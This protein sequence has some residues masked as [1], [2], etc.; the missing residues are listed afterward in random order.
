MT[1]IIPGGRLSPS[2]T[3]MVLGVTKELEPHY[4][5]LREEEEK[6]REE[7]SQ[8]QEKLRKNMYVWNRL[9]RESKACKVR[10]E[11]SEQSMNALAG[12]GV[13]GAAF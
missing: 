11:L 5:K 6:I 2:W 12:E 9:D 10:S 1:P 8:K 13:G 4:R 7:L 3:P